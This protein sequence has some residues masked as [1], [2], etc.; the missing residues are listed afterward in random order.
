MNTSLALSPKILQMFQPLVKF[1][2]HGRSVLRICP[3]N[4]SEPTKNP[5]AARKKYIQA[6]TSLL[7]PASSETDVHFSSACLLT[8]DS[9]RKTNRKRLKEILWQLKHSGDKSVSRTPHKQGVCGRAE[10][11][12]GF[13]RP[14]SSGKENPRIFPHPVRNLP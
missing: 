11:F 9:G 3:L 13:Y 5:S 8:K 12:E 10:T 14:I 4:H 6:D 1:T 2:F 7:S